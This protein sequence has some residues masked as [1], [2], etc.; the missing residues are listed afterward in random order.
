MQPIWTLCFCQVLL[1]N[2]SSTHNTANTYNLFTP[3]P[4]CWRSM[5][6]SS[7]NIKQV[8]KTAKFVSYVSYAVP[9]LPFFYVVKCSKGS[10]YI[11]GT[12]IL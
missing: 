6:R 5:G 10:W 3:I 4:D 1:Q 2:F 8:Q 7:C 9:A 11:D 12:C